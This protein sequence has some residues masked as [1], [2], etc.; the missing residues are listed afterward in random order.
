MPINEYPNFEEDNIQDIRCDYNFMLENNI[1]PAGVSLEELER[2]KD[3]IET[4]LY[5]M[6]QKRFLMQW[7]DL[8]YTQDDVVKEI[9]NTAKIIREKYEN[10]VV[11]GIGGSA[12]GA[13]MLQ[14]ALCHL[15]YNDAPK[16][17][18]NGPKLFVEDNIDPEGI[19]ALFDVIDP[20]KTCFNIITKS[21]NTSETMS[22]LLIVTDI[23]KSRLGSNASSHI[24]ATTDESEGNLRKIAV[25]EGYETFTIPK[26][27]GGRFSVL[28]PVGLL[29]AA[30]IGI[31]IA[32]LLEGA[33]YMES[34]CDEYDIYKNKAYMGA[35]LQVLAMQSGKNI[36][37]MMPYSSALNYFAHWY[38]QLWAESLGKKNDL[39]GMPVYSGQTPVK[40]L[41]VTD[42]HSQ[43]QLYTEGPFDKTIT[44]LCVDKYRDEIEIPLLYELI[45]NVSFLGDKTLNELIKAEEYGTMYALYKAKR[46]F[47]KV[48]LPEINEHTLG[49][50]IQ[51]Y[52][53]MTAFAGE[54]L[55]IN[56]FN[57][58]G[59][60]LGKEV[61]YA[62]MGKPGFEELYEEVK[63]MP[64]G[65]ER[66]IF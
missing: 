21:G 64:E 39:K 56:T 22:Q 6:R 48:S 32:K 11:F 16:F 46:P 36:N 65:D 50:L 7:R 27:V 58:P 61:T 55:E 4:A 49:Q 66:F 1:G 42:Q 37:V 8:P 5:N 41:G 52:E 59:V 26:G 13:R 40:A 18:R 54:L 10:F 51:M 14:N 2:Q 34:I 57:Q 19:K 12:L 45:K 24:I 31:D 3:V 9:E 28:S 35:A 25:A 23:L 63:E 29:P 20:E 53:L 43:I 30:V 60:E 17:I 38:A 62:L 33:A 15:K 44:F 47:A